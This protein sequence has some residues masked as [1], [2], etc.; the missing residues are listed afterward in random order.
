[1]I[2]KQFFDE[3]IQVIHEKTVSMKRGRGTRMLDQKVVKVR[4]CL[5]CFSQSTRRR[6]D[7]LGEAASNTLQREVQDV[8]I[9]LKYG[10][11]HTYKFAKVLK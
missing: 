9:C 4:Y 6:T 3:E 1:M 5:V 7:C 8:L 11:L 2:H 10:N